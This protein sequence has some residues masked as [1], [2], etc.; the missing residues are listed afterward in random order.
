[1]EPSTGATGP[2]GLTGATGATGAES[3]TA[4]P[5]TSEDQIEIEQTVETWLN[6]GD[7]ELMTAA[8]LEQQTFETD[9]EAACRIFRGEYE[10]NDY[11]TE[12]VT[13]SEFSGDA[14]EAIVTITVEGGISADYSLVDDGRGWRIDSVD[15]Q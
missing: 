12:S 10:T 6:D 2:T 15:I 3:S 13:A 5:L 1:M 8:F 14:S 11:A 9:P 4:G 7:C